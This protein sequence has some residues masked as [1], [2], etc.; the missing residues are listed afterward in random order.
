MTAY[1]KR[2]PLAAIRVFCVQCQG[3]SSQTVTGCIDVACPFHSY[4]HG[5]ALEKGRH[6]PVRACRGYC[7]TNCLP[8]ANKEEIR[9]CGGNTAL[10]G[11]CSVFPFRM[12][13]NPNRKPLS[14]KRRAAL[15]EAGEKSRFKFGVGGTKEITA[16]PP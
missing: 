12:G 9:D 7:K 14:E 8:E 15:V 10:L 11:P 2:S 1:P 4:R 6:S 16:R 5:S 13:K 3:D